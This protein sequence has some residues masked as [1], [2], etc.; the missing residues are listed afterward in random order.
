MTL[1][2]SNMLDT[3]KALDWMTIQRTIGNNHST[4]I[5]LFA[6]W[7]IHTSNDATVIEG[8]PSFHARRS[9]PF[10]SDGLF[11]EGDNVV[12]ILEVEGSR[13]DHTIGKIRKH[14]DANLDVLGHLRFAIYVAYSESP[15]GRNPHRTFPSPLT[16]RDFGKFSKLSRDYPNKCIAVVTLEKLVDRQLSEV[17]KKSE[18]YSGHINCV[19]A[20]LYQNGNVVDQFS[21]SAP[22]ANSQKEDAHHGI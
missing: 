1:D 7:Y 21:C 18:Y 17:R 5:G 4:I 2:C 8:A 19:S 6:S 3:L 15:R 11:C 13:H 14:F 12:G 22:A 10:K 9:K 16:D 20:R